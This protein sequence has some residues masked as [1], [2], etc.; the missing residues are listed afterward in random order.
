L[1]AALLLR[2][3]VFGDTAGLT[4][5]YDESDFAPSGP[6]ESSDDADK[7]EAMDG[8]RVVFAL[9]MAAGGSNEKGEPSTEGLGAISV[10]AVGVGRP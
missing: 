3:V 7:A 9:A 10:E 8:W 1:F 2:L 5:R 6:V 4:G